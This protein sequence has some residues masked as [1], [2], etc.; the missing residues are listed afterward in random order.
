[1]KYWEIWLNL[2]FHR[3]TVGARMFAENGKSL[4]GINIRPA[5]CAAGIKII[6]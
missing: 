4:L 2:H 1:M 3:E 6:S 5:M